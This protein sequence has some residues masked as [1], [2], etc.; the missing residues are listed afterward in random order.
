MGSKALNRNSTLDLLKLA[1][2][3]L[4]VFIHVPFYGSLGVVVSTLARFAVPVF[5]I[6]SGF[7]CYGN[8]VA[9]IGKK[10]L[11][12]FY[13]LI[14][15]SVLYNITNVLFAVF[16]D[17]LGGVVEYLRG[18]LSLQGWAELLLFNSPFSA[19]RLWF[20]FALIYVYLLQML[21]S[22]FR[23]KDTAV[24]IISLLLLLVNLALVEGLSA[25][26]IEIPEY[27]TRNFLLTG[28]PFFG[29][30]LSL[31]KY[32][33]KVCS[34]KPA[35][36]ISGFLAGAVL[37]LVSLYFIG[38]N[39]LYLG[40]VLMAVFAFAVAMKYPSVTDSRKLLRLFDCSLGIYIF[41]RPVATAVDVFAKVLSINTESALYI[42]L[43]PILVCVLTTAFT[44]IVKAIADRISVSHNKKTGERQ[45]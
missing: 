34:A 35:L 11:K 3:Y 8:D 31:R 18:F 37:S 45:S 29:I 17:G 38:E 5:F 24:L 19:T 4:V 2:A 7:F 20:L 1:A 30:G 44:L 22:K 28:Y 43:I 41:H 39:V 15:A 10:A 12:I 16:S 33:D 26:G 21:V 13:I 6:S 27:L 9:I 32:Q 14:F 36:M 40:S 25:F 23:V 42:N